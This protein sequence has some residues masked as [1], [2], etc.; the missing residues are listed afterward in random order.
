MKRLAFLASGGGSN[1]QAIL[2]ACQGGRL[3]AEPVLLISNN[4]DAYALQRAEQAGIQSLHMSQKTCGSF[5]ALDQDMVTCLQ[6]NTID[7]VILAGYMKKIGPRL[8]Q[9]YAGRLF[10]IHP[11]LLPKFGGQGMYGMNVHKAVIAAGEKE[12]GATIHCVSGEYDQGRIL[13]QAQVAVLD[14]DT[15]ESL[16]ARVLKE[17]HRLYAETLQKII[18]GKISLA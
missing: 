7:W 13:A 3:Q 8:L 4:S 18:S 14:D 12:S 2:D 1:V 5:E 16:A 15:P 17:E 9:A 10:N 6:E 11:S